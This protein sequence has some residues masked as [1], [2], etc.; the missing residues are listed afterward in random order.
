MPLETAAGG[1]ALRIGVY[2]HA[3]GAQFKSAV[4]A[5]CTENQ[6]HAVGE[7]RRRRRG[8]V[9]EE[10]RRDAPPRAAGAPER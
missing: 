7:G 1:G 4:S 9:E 10:W 5:A 8:R 3:A 2:G 6:E